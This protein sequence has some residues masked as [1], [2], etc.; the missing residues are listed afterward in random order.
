MQRQ[1]AGLD[2]PCGQRRPG[3]GIEVQAGRRG[4]HGSRRTRPDGLVA[5]A[6]G[7]HV[8]APDV[9]RQ[10]DVPLRFEHAGHRRGEAQPVE[11]PL[12]FDDLGLDP[13]GE[14]QPPPGTRRVAGAQL[15]EGLIDGQD[16]LEQQLDAPTA[17]L[18][19]VEPRRQHPRVVDDQQVT[20]LQEADDVGETAVGEVTVTVEVQQTRCA[21][22]GQRLLGDQRLGQV[23]MKI[24]GLHGRRM[25]VEV[26][27]RHIDEGS[28]RVS[29]A[30][31]PGWRNW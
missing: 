18:V 11:R 30:P 29:C 2:T 21:A 31:R 16:P 10:R 24:P 13:G 8:A 1:G 5:L 6:V 19:S 26:A 7:S 12:A 9:R 17:G 28:L 27:G 25:V 22:L 23:E 15:D 20:G 4:R 14:H 3:R